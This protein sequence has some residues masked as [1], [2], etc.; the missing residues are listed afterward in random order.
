MKSSTSFP[1]VAAQLERVAE[2]LGRGDAQAALILAQGLCAVHPRHPEALRL[3][4]V[5]LLQLERVAEGC[6]VLE[7]A[8]SIAPNSVEILSNLASALLMG[9]DANSASERLQQALTLAPGHPSLLNGLGNAM[10][11]LGDLSAARDAYAACTRCA[12]GYVG[13]W[14]NLAAAEL[15]LGALPLAERQVRHALG[16]AEGHP[17]GLLLLGHILAAQKRLAEAEQAYV[18]G[19][20]SAPTDPSFPYQIGL[21]A[22]EQKRYGDAA[23]AQSR[24]L[25]LD[26]SMAQALAQLVFLNR[27]LCDWNDLDALS[28]RLRDAVAHGAADVTPFSF[29]SEPATAAEQLQCARTA[30]QSLWQSSQA[31]RDKLAFRPPIAEKD[32]PLR[33]GFASNGFGSHPTGLLIVAML[34]ALRVHAVELHIFSTAAHSEGP[35]HRRL[36]EAAHA[37]HDLQDLDA[38]TMAQR[39]HA[40]GVELLFDLRVWGGGNISEA[41]ALRPAPVQLNW[42]AYPGTSGAPWID[43]VVADRVV[44]PESLLAAFSETVAYLPRCFQP[45]DNS[46]NVATPPSRSECGLPETGVVYVCFNNSYKLNPASF[47]RMMAILRAVPDSVLWL[48]RGPEDADF[49]LRQAAREAGIDPSRLVFMA[50]MGHNDYLSRYRHADLFLDTAPYNAHTTASDALWAGCP[51]LTVP[52]KTFAARVAASLNE[53]LGMPEMNVADDAAFID[54]GVRVGLDAE[55]RQRLRDTVATRREQSGLFDMSAFAT[56]FAELMQRIAA[57]HRA[58]GAPATLA[59]HLD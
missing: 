5:A 16:M 39:M 59:S 56:D 12:P 29:L 2:S 17:Q 44:L 14:F 13:G 40:S 41:F 43:Y 53:H 26:P 24:A 46:R 3:Q 50:K 36:R 38:A 32:A 45:S 47:A 18:Q 20:Q 8:L 57:H 25:S 54:F 22:E 30:A 31:L 15:A 35:I 58:G 42:L 23:K 4:G 19:A 48:L 11:A 10:R 27:Q 1:A 21:M 51:L 34:E 52:G 55:L 6:A 7:R 49:R 28:T 9:G 37:W 33:V